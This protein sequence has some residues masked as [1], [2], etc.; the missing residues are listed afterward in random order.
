MQQSTKE[1]LETFRERLAECRTGMVS[2]D[3]RAVPMS[4]YVDEDRDSISFLTAQGTI[5]ARATPG[6]ARL[7][8]CND[9]EK[10]YCEIEGSLRL[11]NDRERLNEIWNPIA[12]AFYEEGK[13]DPD[14]MLVEFIPAKA[15]VWLGPGT[16]RFIYETAKANMTEDMPEFGEHFSVRY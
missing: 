2:I 5:V 13:D 10:L 3:G 6:P 16:L 9:S 7:I 4:P 8:V 15:E 14:L 1:Q 11:S 12:A